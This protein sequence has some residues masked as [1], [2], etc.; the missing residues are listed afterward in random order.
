ML[1]AFFTPS[2]RDWWLAYAQMPEDMSPYHNHW[3]VRRSAANAFAQGV[4]KLDRLHPST[5]EVSCDR[6]AT[7]ALIFFFLWLTLWN[8]IRSNM[9]PLER[10]IPLI[11]TV[12]IRY[13][14]TILDLVSR[15]WIRALWGLM[16]DFLRASAGSILPSKFP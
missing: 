13:W 4:V 10:W 2:Y 12:L 3:L 5:V 7:K 1:G 6:C 11:S 9:F 15:R 14:V 16:L 8:S